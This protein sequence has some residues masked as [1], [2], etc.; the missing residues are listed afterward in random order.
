[1]ESYI[2]YGN[3]EE[4][5]VLALARDGDGLAMEHVLKK[6]AFLVRGKARAYFLIGADREDIIQ[7][8]MIGLFKAVKDFDAD[9]NPR[10]SAFADLCITRQVITAIKKATR[11][12]HQPLNTSVSLSKLLFEDE[13][14][15]LLDVIGQDE[16]A[17]PEEVL[18]AKEN[19]LALQNRIR[20]R[21]S[22]MENKVLG[23]YLEGMD[24][25]EI[26]SETGKELKSVDNALQ[27]I[28]KKIQSILKEE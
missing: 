14:K 18:M 2:D 16:S 26:A 11:Q 3:M 21:L 7:E 15:T 27:R 1:M 4:A 6:Y 13:D 23:K 28:K 19:I 25:H 10:F 12:K 24:Y 20:S 8:G 17:N 22:R 5:K 9:A